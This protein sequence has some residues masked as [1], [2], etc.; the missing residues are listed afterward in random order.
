[1][2]HADMQA[3]TGRDAGMDMQTRKHGHADMDMQTWTGRDAAMDIQTWTCPCRQ[4]HANMQL[5]KHGHAEMQ[6]W[7]C[8]HGCADML[9]TCGE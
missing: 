6:S 4:G 3:W 2:R 8:R 7:T 5:R 1:M 9:G